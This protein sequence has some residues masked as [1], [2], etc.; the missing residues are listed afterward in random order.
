MDCIDLPADL[1]L[2]ASEAVASGR[3]RDTADIV[4]AGLDLL[5]RQEPARAAF[6]AS[7]DEAVAE[8]DRDGW[9]NSYDVAAEMDRIIAAKDRNTA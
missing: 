1:E 9:H 3:Y 8:A 6:V 2:F 4:R 5:R 7:L